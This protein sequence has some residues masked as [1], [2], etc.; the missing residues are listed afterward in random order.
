M[1]RITLFIMTLAAA[2]LFAACGAPADNKP[3]NT[4]TNANTA[5]PVAAAPTKEALFE[6]D[7][8]ANEAWI[9]GDKAYFE[10]FLGDKF[11][12]FER[13][14]RMSR[15]ELLAMIGSFKCDVKT[16]ALEDP[17]MVKI[18]ADTYVMSYKGN[19]DGSC[20]G[21]DGKAE[22]LPSP[23][24]AASLYTRSGE[25]WVGAFHSETMII[26]P[27][28]PPPPPAKAEAK[29]LFGSLC[30][31]CHGAGGRGDG[32]AAAGLNPKPRDYSDKEW[33]K[34]VTDEQIAT[35]ILKGGAAIGKSPTMPPA[36]Q[37]ESKPEVVAEL[38]KMIRVIGE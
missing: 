37:L 31:T 16:W 23:M 32:A 1:K 24:R 18:D 9:K 19:F 25:K 17:Q 34:S 35:V 20:T 27:K 13:G 26:D 33:Q 14:Q 21:P 7:K 12:S 28:A 30:S 4:N 22:K 6:M 8:K 5:K 11:V 10:S 38:V 2:A 36:P 29:A 15:A 3:A